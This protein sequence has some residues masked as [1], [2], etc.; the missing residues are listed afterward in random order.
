MWSGRFIEIVIAWILERSHLQFTN[1]ARNGTLRC[2]IDGCICHP[3]SHTPDHPVGTTND[4]TESPSN[5]PG[6]KLIAGQ[7]LDSITRSPCQKAWET[8]DVNIPT[9][10]SVAG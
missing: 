4:V 5:Q 9:P 3:T 7:S 10:Q 6:S 2:I 1:A 8:Y